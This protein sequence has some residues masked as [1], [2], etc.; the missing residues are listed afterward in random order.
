MAVARHL[1]AQVRKRT[2]L[3]TLK[4]KFCKTS[5]TPLI[6]ITQVCACAYSPA[7][8]EDEKCHVANIPGKESGTEL[9]KICFRD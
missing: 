3:R 8:L 1:S 4:Y 9:K 6:F 2:N 7:R 5:Y